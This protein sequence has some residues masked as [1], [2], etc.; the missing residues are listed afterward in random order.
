MKIYVVILIGIALAMD[1]AGVSLAI[2]LKEELDEE[3][4]KYIW[5]FGIFQ[6]LF[7]FLGGEVGIYFSRYIASIPSIIGG[8]SLIIVGSV[9]VISGKKNDEEK[10]GINKMIIPLGICFSY[11]F[12][13]I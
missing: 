7:T 8:I 13:Y 6:A 12:Y 10:E 1:A 11:R 9:M 5:T 4:S 3:K 2:G